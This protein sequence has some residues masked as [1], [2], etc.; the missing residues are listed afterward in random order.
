VAPGRAVAAS[1]AAAV[2]AVVT[3]CAPK[4]Q[5]A[6][7]STVAVHG[8]V[9][10]PDGSPATGL[11]VGLVKQLDA[12]EMLGGLFVIGVS[13]GLACVGGAPNVP[14]ICA[15][16]PSS[17]TDGD[18]RFSFQLSGGDTQGSFGG[19]ST[20]SIVTSLTSRAGEL[21]GPATSE[22]LELQATDLEVPALRLWRPPVSLTPA[23]P[24]LRVDWSQPSSDYGGSPGY[25]VR[26][27][28]AAS[29]PVWT[30]ADSHPGAALD[31]RLL[32]DS[33][34][35]AIVEAHTQMPATGTTARF[36]YRS[37][38][39]AYRGTA[40]APASRG[41]PCAILR[42]GA[43]V[44][45]TPCALTDGDLVHPA[46]SGNPAAL[47]SPV[48]GTPAAAAPVHVRVDLGAAVPVSL[49]VVRG[50][51]GCP[52]EGSTDGAVGVGTLRELS[53]WTTAA[54]AG[55]QSGGAGSGGA[56]AAG[57]PPAATSPATDLRP[58]AVGLV[59]LAAAV[60]ALAV[61]LSRRRSP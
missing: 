26:F 39:V 10:A 33:H 20:F 59:A 40:G 22:D 3:A 51:P 60:A 48:A 36:T 16:Q 47:P 50:C 17:V 53:V 57:A 4:S 19:A 25:D 8:R 9:L 14:A 61:V 46:L 13:L 43:T 34:G 21:T 24:S 30:F 1:A 2:L 37:A 23:G 7:G 38:T 44:P 55:A 32:E 27:Q 52:V 5:V 12:G 29:L 54:S 15:R 49:V 56:P 35:G 28:D 41:R 45:L 31:A 11:R 6:S 42:G 58:L 18:G